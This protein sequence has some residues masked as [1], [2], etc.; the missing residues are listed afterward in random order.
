MGVGEGC[1]KQWWRKPA[2]AGLK[3]GFPSLQ[4]FENFLDISFKM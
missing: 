1:F 3:A 2:Y 4:G